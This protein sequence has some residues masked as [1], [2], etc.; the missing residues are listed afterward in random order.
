MNLGKL[1]ASLPTKNAAVYAFEQ[2][3]AIRYP[4]ASLAGDVAAAADNLRHWGIGPGIRVG[5]YA[6]NSYRWLV[7]DL[8]LMELD[9]VSVPF[10]DDFA[11]KIDRAL[12]DRYQL[13]CCSSQKPDPS[14]FAENRPMSLI[15][16]R[17]MNACMP[18]NGRH[19]RK[20]PVS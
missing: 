11:G 13:L 18:S 6:P 20:M 1:G 19:W 10:T 16:M 15:S 8:A 12:L 14:R 2:G 4:F 5:I 9:A 3:K 17:I 7:H